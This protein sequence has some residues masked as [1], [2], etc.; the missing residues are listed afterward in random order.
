MVLYLLP[1]PADSVDVVV[2]V[3]MGWHSRHA[4]IVVV[5]VAAEVLLRSLLVPA[6]LLRDIGIGVVVGIV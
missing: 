6:V 3:V 4:L 5:L 2:V 1:F